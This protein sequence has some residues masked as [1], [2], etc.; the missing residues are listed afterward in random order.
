[1]HQPT[2]QGPVL[3]GTQ[4]ALLLLSLI[5]LFFHLESPASDLPTSSHSKGSHRLPSRRL[6]PALE[7][8]SVSCLLHG[9][10]CRTRHNTQGI[11][12]VEMTELMDILL[13]NGELRKVR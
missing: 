3:P 8:L 1:M 10:V 5:R 9:W 7:S 4:E 6:L 11:F 12:V 2:D 13:S